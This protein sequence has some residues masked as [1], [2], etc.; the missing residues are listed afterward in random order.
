MF[1]DCG[2]LSET[3]LVLLHPKGKEVVAMV[4][5]YLDHVFTFFLYPSGI[6]LDINSVHKG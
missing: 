5:I 6:M 3:L 4:N 1:L 2:A